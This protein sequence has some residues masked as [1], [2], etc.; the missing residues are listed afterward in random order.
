MERLLTPCSGYL[1]FGHT[2]QTLIPSIYLHRLDDEL[3]SLDLQ[4]EKRHT[5]CHYRL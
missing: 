4:I 2:G 5:G 3:E 1:P